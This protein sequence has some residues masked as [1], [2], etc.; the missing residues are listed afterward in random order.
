MMLGFEISLEDD[1]LSGEEL[2]SRV[3]SGISISVLRCPQ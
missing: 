3:F 2:R 1:L